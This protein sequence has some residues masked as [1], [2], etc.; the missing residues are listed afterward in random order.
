MPDFLTHQYFGDTVF[1]Q[2]PS[3]IQERIK[4][5]KALY[6]IGL[7]GPDPL[8]FYKPMK[9][10]PVCQHG[11]DLHKLNGSEYFANSLSVLKENKDDAEASLAYQAG[12][13]CHYSLDSV[14]H[15]FV[16]RY[17]KE[18]GVSHSDMEGEFERY[19]YVQVGKDP[20]RTNP[21]DHISATRANSDI[22]SRFSMGLS[23]KDC[24]DALRSF[25]MYRSLFYCPNAVKRSIIYG[26]LKA[27]GAYRS[28]RGQIVN[29]EPY[30]N[31]EKSDEEL[32]RL[33]HETVSLA[34]RL[35]PNFYSAFESDDPELFLV[36]ED[37]KIPF[38]GMSI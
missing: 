37:L 21:A 2:L 5:Y 17:E 6:D 8:M 25:R 23:E 9:S 28:Y 36:D 19:L 11:Y 24:Y 12:Y 13:I 38:D 16:N 31:T 4:P 1:K 20:Y 35:I 30:P 18:A 26:V 7:Q 14:C 32:F 15:T 34:M 29:T 10:N 33:V 22:V 27:A 3:D